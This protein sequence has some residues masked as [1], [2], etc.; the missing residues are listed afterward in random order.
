VDVK[1]LAR[2]LGFPAFPLTPTILPLPLPAR[3]HVRFGEPMRFAGSPDDD[4]A[5]LERKVAEVQGAVRA[6]LER[7]L[8]ERRSVYL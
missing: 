3:Y 8:A 4:D 6:L 5:E 1:P 2:L 7:G